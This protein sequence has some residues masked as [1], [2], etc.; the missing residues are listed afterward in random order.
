M[1]KFTF[2]REEVIDQFILLMAGYDTFQQGYLSKQDWKKSLYSASIYI[3]K[4][5]DNDGINL[6]PA[7]NILRMTTNDHGRCDKESD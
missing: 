2:S 1:D 6:T 7:K 4:L 3:D 5:I